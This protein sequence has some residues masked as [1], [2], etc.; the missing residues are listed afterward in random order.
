MAQV[1]KKKI[2]DCFCIMK[3]F[4]ILLLFLILKSLKKKNYD[5][6]FN[7]KEPIHFLNLTGRVLTLCVNLTT[8]SKTRMFPRNTQGEN[9][10]QP[11]KQNPPHKHKKNNLQTVLR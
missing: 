11:T 2:W 9:K 1:Q 8:M 4:V 10:Q 6:I 5:Q 7:A 3:L